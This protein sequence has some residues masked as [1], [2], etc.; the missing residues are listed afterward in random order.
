MIR[1]K[2]VFSEAYGALQAKS[3]AHRDHHARHGLGNRHRSPVAGLWDGFLD[4]HRQHLQGLCQHAVGWVLLAGAP[5]CRPE[6]AKRG[7]MSG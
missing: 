5:R 2:D 6:E 3:P 7:P 4:C 1:A